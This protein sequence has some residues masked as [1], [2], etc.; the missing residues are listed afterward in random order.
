MCEQFEITQSRL[1]HNLPYGL[2]DGKLVTVQ[3]VESGL[4]C[5]CVCPACKEV[6]IARKGQINAHHFAHHKENCEYAVETALHIAAKEILEQE[7]IIVLP[8]LVERDDI[9]TGKLLTLSNE[10]EIKLDQVRLEENQEGFKPDV[11]AIIGSKE[12]YI[13]VA[14]THFVDYD[15]ALKVEQK[16]VSMIE[17]DLSYLYDGFT[18]EELKEAV[19]RDVFNKYW[20]YNSKKESLFKQKMKPI[21]EEH[22]KLEAE[23][24]KLEKE[25]N[26][27][28]KI[29]EERLDKVYKILDQ[30]RMIA[31]N[32]G[33]KLFTIGHHV[34]K[35][36]ISKTVKKYRDNEVISKL[37]NGAYWNGEIY[38]KGNNGRYIYLNGEQIYIFP[39]EGAIPLTEQEDNERR[40]LYG[41]LMNIARD[42]TIYRETCEDCPFFDSYLD[43]D[44]FTVACGFGKGIKKS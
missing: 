22:K 41:Q 33:L 28:E 9:Y 39:F 14:V 16:G 1:I 10:L 24:I 6:L 8:E 34:C 36:L 20:I 44:E 29:E 17:I 7:K 15:K 18:E 25:R 19:I 12:L 21:I 4:K 11:I 3:E 43:E 30:K 42:S 2:K 40:R 26:R 37:K 32:K 35:H 38:G 13:E 31:E 5:G 23:R 27:K